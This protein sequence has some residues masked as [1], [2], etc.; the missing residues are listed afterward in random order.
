M[1]DFVHSQRIARWL[2]HYSSRLVGYLPDA[3]QRTYVVVEQVAPG[4]NGYDPRRRARRR[5]VY[6]ENL[7]MRMR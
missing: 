6:G 4:E 3:L 2:V 7:R 1:T 5:D